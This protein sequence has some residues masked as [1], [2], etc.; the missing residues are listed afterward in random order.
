[1]DIMKMKKS[2]FKYVP[3]LEYK[4]KI[5]KFDS[6]IIVPTNRKHESGYKIINYILVSGSTPVAQICGCSDVL[7]INGIGGRGRFLPNGEFE[8]KCNPWSIDLLPCGYFRLFSR[9]KLEF[10]G[11]LDAWL[12]DVE[13][14]STGKK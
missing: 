8:D 10:G 2:D 13:I 12:S 9:G 14:F 11:A 5:P 4:E 1:M 7:H 3:K 6:L